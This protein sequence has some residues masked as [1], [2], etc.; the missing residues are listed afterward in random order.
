MEAVTT[1]YNFLN[2]KEL[3]GK[4]MKKH[5]DTA[6]TFL[7][8]IPVDESRKKELLAFADSLMVREM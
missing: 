7:K 5:Y 2:V 4:E 3:A 6:I 1:I 8:D